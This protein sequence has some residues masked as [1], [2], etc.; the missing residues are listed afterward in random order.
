MSVFIIEEIGLNHNGDLDIARKLIDV[1]AFAG[2]DAVKFQK[3]TPH[4]CVPDAQK[5]VMRDTPW[6][7]MSYLD[8]RYRVEF[9]RE[10]YDEI[11]RYCREKDIAWL[12]SPWDIPSYEFLQHYTPSYCKIPSAMLTNHDLLHV[13]ASGKQKT[14]I[15]T[16]MSTMQEIE[17][18]VNLFETHNCPFELMHCTST[19]PM[20]SEEANLR[21]IPMLRE[22]FGCNVGYSG[23]ERGLQITL[24]AVALGVTSVERHVTLDRTMWGSDHA[25]SLEPG[26][27]MKLVRDIRI[28]EAALGDG[29]KRVFDSELPI[30]KKLRG[31]RDDNGVVVVEQDGKKVTR[32][33]VA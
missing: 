4:L 7:R 31:K 1:A 16:G 32:S 30:R 13:V 10:V 2:C 25:A 14:F 19:Y 3:R 29:V 6:G 28:I 8:Y 22:R 15:S 9:E 18:A 21:C 24:A 23:H 26:G 5:H 17:V 11:D 27:L 12:A 20:E 33:S